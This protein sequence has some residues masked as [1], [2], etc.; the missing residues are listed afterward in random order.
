[1]RYYVTVSDT[2]YE[3]DIDEN[4]VHVDGEPVEVSALQ[5][6]GTDVHSFLVD[7]ESHRVVASSSGKGGWDLHLKG[8]HERA[9]VLDEHTKT[10][11]DMS[12]ARA[13]PMGPRAVRAPMPGLVVKV[14]VEEGDLVEVGTGLLIVEAMKMENELSAEAPARVGV[15]H[16]AAGQ[17]VEKD[18]I[19]MDMLSPEAEDSEDTP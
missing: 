4:G 15:I 5:V 2:T 17:A 7:G 8:R 16:V 11:R 3:V 6:A 10:L 19:L 14:E 1:M 12:A 9:E 13:G 18:Q